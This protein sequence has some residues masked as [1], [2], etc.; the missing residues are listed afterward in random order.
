MHSPT[1]TAFDAG[2]LV[3]LFS[4]IVALASL[5]AC[6]TPGPKI[7]AVQEAHQYEARAKGNY[8][9]PGPPS[10]PWG[11]Y[12]VEAATKYDVPER[13]VREVIRAESSGHVMDTSAPGAMGLM[14]VMPATYDELR[15]RYDLGEDAYDPHDNIMAGTA[16]LRLM[17]DRFGYPALFAAYNAGPG[18]TADWLA[19]RSRLPAE[20]VGYLRNVTGGRVSGALTLASPPPRVLFALRHDLA[21]AQTHAIESPVR[22]GV[23]AIRNGQR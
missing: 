5:A 19:G 13:W 21:D 9:P 14:Q 18:R 22:G 2:R 12:I 6:A 17:R 23:F 7:S 3:R 10:D 1:S 4:C 20:T 16:Y 11:P 15:G 8:V